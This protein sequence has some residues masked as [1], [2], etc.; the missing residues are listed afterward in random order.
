MVAIKPLTQLDR[1]DILR[2]IVGYTT[3]ET[4]RITRTEPASGPVFTFE[5]AR[6][7]QPKRKRYDHL[8]PETMAFYEGVIAMGFSYGVYL[9]EECVGI[10]LVE[11]RQWNKSLFVLEFHVAEE[12][13]RRGIGE[14]LM[15][16]VIAR[17]VEE[18]MRTV[19]CETQNTNVPAI[20][21]YRRLGF[22]IDGVDISYY[23]N[24]DYPDGEIAIFLKRALT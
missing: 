7:S 22:T 13:Q 21:F 1:D 20:D 12:H 19:A 16:V 14:K 4:Y 23:S 24:N 6:L 15:E 18:G 2:I 3:H 10:A 9:E 17:G 5:R 11:P 8:G